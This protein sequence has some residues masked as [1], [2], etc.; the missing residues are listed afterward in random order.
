MCDKGC[1]DTELR[2]SHPQESLDF[3]GFARGDGL[4]TRNIMLVFWGF[5]YGWC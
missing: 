4:L 5:A 2:T 1:V 3:W